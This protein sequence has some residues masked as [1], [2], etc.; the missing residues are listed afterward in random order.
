MIENKS[1]FLFLHTYA[2][3]D[4]QWQ[5]DDTIEYI[6]VSIFSLFQASFPKTNC[7]KML[8]NKEFASYT[9]YFLSF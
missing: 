6:F 5:K 8:I 4:S 3:K 9:L 7:F 1:S 2:D